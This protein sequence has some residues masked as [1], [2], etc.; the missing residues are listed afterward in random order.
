MVTCYYLSKILHN[1]INDCGNYSIFH[2]RCR[3]GGSSKKRRD[4]AGFLVVNISNENNET[5]IPNAVN[6]NQLNGQTEPFQL[7]LKPYVARI[8]VEEKK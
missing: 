6:K 8:L 1:E 7:H 5:E 2:R 3:R 4:K